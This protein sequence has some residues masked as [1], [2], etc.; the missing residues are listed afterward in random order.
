MK[1][2][3]T[4]E[5]KEIALNIL[6]EV[7]SFC[8][9]NNL[10]YSLAYGTLL[11][12]VRHG[13]Y[14]PWDDDIDI[15][16]PRPDYNLLLDTFNADTKKPQWLKAINPLSARAIH[17]F[18]KIIDT[19]TIK[20]E[21][22]VNYKNKD[23]LGIDIDIFPLDG[24]SSDPEKRQRKFQFTKR[25]FKVFC[26]SN[27]SPKDK[28]PHKWVIIKCLNVLRNPLVRV[29]DKRAQEFDFKDS[30]YVGVQVSMYSGKFDCQRKNIYLNRARMLFEGEEFWIPKEFDECLT[31][32]YGEYMQ[33]PPVDKRITH[34]AFDCYWMDENC[35]ETGS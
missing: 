7:A 15:C 28:T 2:I 31:Y 9:R 4:Q 21:R 19:R 14:I 22:G 20:V 11:G 26:Y 33:L 12:A 29:L 27:I 34:H 25:I 13:G 8:D 24:W 18:I 1:K 23:T 32:V 6:I 16:M 5:C 17:P 3:N 35:S 10:N 30:E